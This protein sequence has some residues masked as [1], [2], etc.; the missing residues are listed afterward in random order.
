M[1]KLNISEVDTLRIQKQIET[2]DKVKK[3]N[4]HNHSVESTTNTLQIHTRWYKAIYII[5]HKINTFFNERNW[6]IRG[7]EPI[8]IHKLT[9]AEQWL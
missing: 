2:A 9:K 7:L 6:S 4:K 1:L 3:I 5:P 8:C